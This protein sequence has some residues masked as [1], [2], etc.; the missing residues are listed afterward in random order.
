MLPAPLL[1]QPEAGTAHLLSLELRPKSGVCAIPSHSLRDHE[2]AAE[3]WV[4]GHHIA[5]PP[6]AQRHRARASEIHLAPGPH[7]GCWRSALSLTSLQGVAHWGPEPS[8]MPAGDACWQW[9][10]P[11]CPPST[12]HSAHPRQEGPCRSHSSL[13]LLLVSRHRCC[14][15]SSIRSLKS[16]SGK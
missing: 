1:P 11:G 10:G 9:A 8:V 12:A 3:P 15:A 6:V 5:E 4:T 16:P 13:P 7:A 2:A 14:R